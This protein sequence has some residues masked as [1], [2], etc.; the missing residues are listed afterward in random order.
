MSSVCLRQKRLIS[1]FEQLNY[2]EITLSEKNTTGK[3]IGKIT[4][5]Q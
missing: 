3:L 2:E 1:R 4:F 5:V